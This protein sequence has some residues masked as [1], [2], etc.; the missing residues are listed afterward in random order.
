M[1]YKMQCPNLAE[2]TNVHKVSLSCGLRSLK[3]I[4]NFPYACYS[5]EVVI[6]NDLSL[7]KGGNE[8]PTS[9]TRWGVWY[10]LLKDWDLLK[11]GYQL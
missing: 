7:G 9:I 8:R 11:F 1:G 4:G 3:L 10:S 2:K 5:L 6:V